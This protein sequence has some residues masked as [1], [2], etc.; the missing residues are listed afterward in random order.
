MSTKSFVNNRFTNLPNGRLVKRFYNRWLQR[1]LTDGGG[2]HFFQFRQQS[3][4]I[5]G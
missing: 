1:G 2:Q 5:I 4:L 3:G